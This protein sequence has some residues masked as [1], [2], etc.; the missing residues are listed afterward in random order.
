MTEQE[1]LGKKRWLIVGIVELSYRRMHASAPSAALQYW[2]NR[3]R[4]LKLCPE[5]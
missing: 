2:F 3:S 5:G 1:I 4:E